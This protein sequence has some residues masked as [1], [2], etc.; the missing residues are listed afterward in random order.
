MRLISEWYTRYKGR[1]Y[2]PGEAFEADAADAESLIAT[3]TARIDNEESSP[4]VPEA[5][6]DSEAFD[7]RERQR[8]T[9]HQR[10]RYKRRDMKADE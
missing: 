1:I 5:E 3:K 2:Q 7:A 8:L 10:R 9:S 6:E 4:I